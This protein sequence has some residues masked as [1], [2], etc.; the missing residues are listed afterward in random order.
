MATCMSGLQTWRKAP[1]RPV[2]PC[3][4]CT[5]VPCLRAIHRR[6]ALLGA[7]PPRA[8][9]KGGQLPQGP[10]AHSRQRRHDR[11]LQLL[12][13]GSPAYERAADVTRTRAEAPGHT[14]CQAALPNACLQ[15]VGACK[16]AVLTTQAN[17]LKCVLSR[18]YDT[19]WLAAAGAT[20]RVDGSLCCAECSSEASVVV[21]SSERL[22]PGGRHR[23]ACGRPYK[24]LRRNIVG[25]SHQQRKESGDRSLA[26]KQPPCKM[27]FF[28]S[29]YCVPT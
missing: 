12:H 14:A 4:T 22:E 2:F 3:R 7:A 24:A 27:I 8:A 19:C 6:C 1:R 17:I 28:A 9:G 29:F 26:R 20:W 13:P 23:G 11:T 15:Q 25:G 5:G 10:G 18:R 21:L 16:E